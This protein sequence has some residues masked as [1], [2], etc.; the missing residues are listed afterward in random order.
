LAC[1]PSFS[2]TLQN[3]LKRLEE[4][5]SS[6]LVESFEMSE[7][8]WTPDS[9]S[10]GPSIYVIQMVMWLTTTMENMA[11]GDV[12]K[13]T[14]YTHAIQFIAKNLMVCLVRFTHRSLTMHRNT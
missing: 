8:E 7:Y 2:Q 10:G 13:N 14:V 11:L 12:Y 5:I 4:V 3:A 9:S 1:R 6:K